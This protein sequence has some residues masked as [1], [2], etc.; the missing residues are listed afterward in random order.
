MAGNALRCVA[1][2]LYDTGAVK[3]KQIKI[4]T[5]S[6]VKE[7]VIKTKNQL[8]SKIT[9]NMG[10]AELDPKKIPANLPL[11]KIINHPVEIGGE[12]FNI[13]CVSMGNPHCVTF[14]GDV[15][16]ADVA[17]LGKRFETHR[18]F[19]NKI[20]AEFVTVIDRRTIKLRVWE[21]GNGETLSCG[22]GACA[23]VVAA[24]LNG[25]IDKNAD[26]KAIVK[27]GEL[28]V[29]Y[30]GETVFLTGSAKKVFE[31]VVEI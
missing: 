6:G 23:A 29:R 22:T 21:R 9:V 11:D 5:L 20:N 3:S 18:L 15:D 16:G 12:I 8:A 2:F 19:P 30:D 7:A 4:E 28:I 27:G 14:C 24:A 17:R 10:K 25:F 1:K 31:G 26:I 13:T